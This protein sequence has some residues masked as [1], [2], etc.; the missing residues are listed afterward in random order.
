MKFLIYF[1]SALILAVAAG[2]LLSYETGRIVLTYGEWTIQSSLSLFVLCFLVVFFVGYLTVRV[3]SNVIRFPK[4]LERWKKQRRYRRSERY[5]NQG[6][7]AMIEGRWQQA[8]TAFRKGAGYSSLPLINYIGAARAA[9]HQGAVKRRDHY[10]RLAHEYAPDANFAVGLTQAEL[11]MNQ[12]QTEQAYATLQH[13]DSVKPGSDQIKL[14]MLDASSE[15]ND[16]QQTLALLQDL[17]SKGAMPIQ[18]IRARQLQAYAGLLHYAG[19]FADPSK[20]AEEWNKIPKKLRNELYL[21]EVYVNEYLKFEDTAE[22]EALLRKTLRRKWDMALA[23]LY[24]LVKG[25]APEKQLTFAEKLLSEHARD[26]VLLLT[27]GRLCKRIELWG[28]ARTYLE[29][30]IRIEPYAETYHELATLHEQLGEADKAS[31]YF[32]K[33]L[34]LAAK[35]RMNTSREEN[36]NISPRISMDSKES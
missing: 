2:M 30:S 9:Q 13:L 35:I 17:E 14:M 4:N 31:E 33:G 20:L 28:K 12:Q 11:Q 21:I 10:L 27:L 18:K 16:W 6:M 23:R 19:Q 24:G 26:P 22:C 34:S 15:L 25:N 3:I 7:L 36:K 1:L 5:L 8:E 32:R 29:E